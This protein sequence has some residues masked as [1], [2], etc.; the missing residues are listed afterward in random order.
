LKQQSRSVSVIYG[1]RADP[2]VRH[3]SQGKD[4]V[5]AVA[6]HAR[7]VRNALG[8]SAV[9]AGIKIEAAELVT[10]CENDRGYS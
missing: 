8:S 2:C 4:V 5:L 9:L 6:R 7:Y 10:P 3:I 1:A